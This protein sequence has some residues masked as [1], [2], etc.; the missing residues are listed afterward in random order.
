MEDHAAVGGV[1]LVAVAVPVGALAVDLHIARPH[2]GA[3]TPADP[4]AG[5][6]E[7]RAGAVVEAAG[8]KDRDR[9][10][11]G[12]RE[13]VGVEGLPRPGVVEDGLGDAG[14][15]RVGLADECGLWRGGL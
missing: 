14:D 6:G 3:G 4:H 1:S 11:V 12:R 8:G 10:A 13:A 5:V 2:E 9:L 15:R 7:V